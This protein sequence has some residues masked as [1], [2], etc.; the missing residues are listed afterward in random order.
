MN[1]DYPVS[2]LVR[3]RDEDELTEALSKRER[4]RLVGT[5]SSQAFL[6]GPDEEVDV[7]STA[8]M[9][10]ILRLEA[11]DLTCSVE[12]G[13]R[14]ED[15]D[16]ALAD[17]N[18]WLPCGGTGT[19]GGIFAG[20]RE[21]PLAPAQAEPR[22]LLLGL[23]AVLTDGTRFKSGARVVKNVAGFDLQKLFVGS[24]GRLFAVTSMHLKLRPRPRAM[25]AFELRDLALPAAISLL[26]GIRRSSTPP[27]VL[28]LERQGSTFVL[29]GSIG[30]D[31]DHLA[32][33]IGE[34]GLLAT[35]SETPGN[36]P[37]DP[38]DGLETVQG[39]VSLKTIPKL[40]EQLPGD[41]PFALH[42]QRFSTSLPAAAV[43]RLLKVLPTI[44]GSGE[45]VAGAASRRGRTSAVD[46]VVAKLETNLASTLDPRGAL[47]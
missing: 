37:G 6:K 20:D 11:D 9:N 12:P 26:L 40:L 42:G 45:I 30:G 15:L 14:R 13:V 1:F 19:L 7:V 41:A 16:A 38:V 44:G 34:F 22:S 43:D 36:R 39:L 47:R 10:R 23:T 33:W 17:H 18:L 31:P 8:D 27:L 4:V 35:D 2:D 21:G 24:R 3:V 46:P 25:V 28:S 32:T 5:G 29:T